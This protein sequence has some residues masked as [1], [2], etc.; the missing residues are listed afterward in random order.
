MKRI[1]I[2]GFGRIGRTFA[3]TI[4]QDPSA[5]KQLAIAV[6]NVG[7]CAPEQIGHLFKYDTIMGTYP[8][9]VS[10]DTGTLTVAG[11]SITVIAECEPSRIPWGDHG[12]DWV[13]ECT[14]CFTDRIS[15]QQHIDAGAKKVLISAPCK[16][17][18]ITIIPGVNVDSYDAAKHHIVALGSCT[19][20]CI[21]PMVKVIK[22]RFTLTS[23]LM[24]TTHAYTNTQ[25][26][27]DIEDSELRKS[28]AAALNII[29]TTTGA[30]KV[31]TKIFP[32]LEGKIQ[33]L[34]IRVPVPIVSLVDF[35]FVAQEELSTEAI[36]EA[37][38]SAAAGPLKGIV[39]YTT[40]PLVSSDFR[41]HPASCIIDS[42]LTRAVGN[43]GKVF[44]WYDNEW[45]YSQR[46]K[47]FLLHS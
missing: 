36:N 33:A 27:L 26:L 47:D 4:L 11:R 9:E 18:D 35:T 22:E 3:R 30:D 43:Q 7:P 2:N 5:L 37:F 1:A 12:I 31:I 34:A 24:T 15:S 19:T 20:N 23:G 6:I 25:V 28:R 29:P 21:V 46:L 42:P 44:G 39:D 16:D 41:G 13:I 17:E 32:E 8:G 10:Y 45:G 40:E 14:G 38:A